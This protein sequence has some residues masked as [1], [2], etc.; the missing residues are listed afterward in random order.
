MSSQGR[1][2][3]G[4][5]GKQKRQL[6]GGHEG[7]RELFRLWTFREYRGSLEERWEIKMIGFQGSLAIV[8]A[9][10]EL[11]LFLFLFIHQKIY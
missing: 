4:C 9:V 8:C 7:C 1:D 11:A 2:V 10:L 5:E 6:P 3:A